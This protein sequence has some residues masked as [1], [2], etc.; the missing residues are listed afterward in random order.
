MIGSQN[1]GGLLVNGDVCIQMLTP[2]L[3]T[4]V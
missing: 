3:S 1:Q 2:T 4:S